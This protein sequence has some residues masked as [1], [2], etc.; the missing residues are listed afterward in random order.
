MTKQL[1]LMLL[2]VAVLMLAGSVQNP[3]LPRLIELPLK[4]PAVGNIDAVKTWRFGRIQQATRAGNNPD[5][6]IDI[7]LAN[8]SV[9]TVIGPAAQLRELARQ[10][11]WFDPVKQRPGSGDYVERQIAFGVDAQ[12]RIIALASLEPSRRDHNRLRRA[13][14]G[15]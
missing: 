5:I 14:G 6:S 15:R 12:G 13:L 3:N 7:R 4:F 11:E 8:N 2:A 1:G 10:S 9:I